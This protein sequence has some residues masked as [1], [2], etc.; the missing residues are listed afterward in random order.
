MVSQSIAQLAQYVYDMDTGYGKPD[1]RFW[2]S[3]NL[4]YPLAALV[5]VEEDG[6]KRKQEIGVSHNNFR[7]L[8]ELIRAVVQAVGY[9]WDEV[10]R[11]VLNAEVAR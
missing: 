8:D 1:K 6:E 7:S 11:V 10:Q 5:E 9:D 2:F 3:P 4:R